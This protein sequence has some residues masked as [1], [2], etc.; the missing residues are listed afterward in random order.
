MNDTL[1]QS[2]PRTLMEVFKRLPEGT[3]IQLI[4]NQLVMT[5]A[6]LLRH[7][8]LLNKINFELLKVVAK[9]RLGEVFVAPLDVYLDDT[10]AYQPDIIFISKDNKGIIHDDGL[11]GAPDL[12][13]ELLSP[14]TARYDL[15]EKKY[16]Y[17]RSGVLEYWIVDPAN[18]EVEGYFLEDGC[19]GDPIKAKGLIQSKILDQSFTF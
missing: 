6:P 4:E 12:V 1:V 7:Q 14:S 10:N 17:E 2:P 5:P 13:I 16:V 3:L 8:R 15:Q 19:Y 9:N 11:H 18:K